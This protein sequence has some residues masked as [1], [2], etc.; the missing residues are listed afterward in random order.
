MQAFCACVCQ[1]LSFSLPL[2]PTLIQLA[3]KLR[4]PQL[5]SFSLPLLSGL[6]QLAVLYRSG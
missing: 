5:L 3:F 2:L 4:G 1:L 6:T